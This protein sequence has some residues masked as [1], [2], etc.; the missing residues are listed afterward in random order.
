M[1]SVALLPGWTVPVP[2]QLPANSAKGPVAAA[3]A[4]RSE[5]ENAKTRA[6][7]QH[8]GRAADKNGDKRPNMRCKGKFPFKFAL[9]EK[10]FVA[11]INRERGGTGSRTSMRARHDGIKKAKDKCL[12]PDQRPLGFR[13]V[14]TPYLDLVRQLVQLTTC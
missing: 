10:K 5:M 4:G 6:I 11:R 13:R 14:L 9:K 3:D 7:R 1:R 8:P 12:A 2:D